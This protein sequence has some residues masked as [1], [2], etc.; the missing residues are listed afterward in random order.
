MNKLELIGLLQAYTGI[1]ILT[2]NLI[3]S[4][5]ANP[6]PF[7]DDFINRSMYFYLGILIFCAV[8]INFNKKEVRRKNKQWR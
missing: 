7:I 3:I 5:Y 8:Y 6:I 4:P 1:F 2:L